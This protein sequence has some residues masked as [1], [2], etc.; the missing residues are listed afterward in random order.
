MGNGIEV[1]EVVDGI[2]GDE[3]VVVDAIAVERIVMV[4]G[5]APAELL[6]VGGDDLLFQIKCQRE[7]LVHR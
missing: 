2:V 5:L 6:V 7:A 4:S 1:V 3:D